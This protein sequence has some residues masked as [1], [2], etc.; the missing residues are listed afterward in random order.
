MITRHFRF[1]IDA[2]SVR[3]VATLMGHSIFK[4]LLTDGS[5]YVMTFTQL[6]SLKQQGRYTTRIEG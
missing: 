5:S 4:Q 2:T 1:G 6:L 3:A